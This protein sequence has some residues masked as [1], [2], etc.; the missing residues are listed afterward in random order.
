MRKRLTAVEV[1]QAAIRERLSA[2]ESRI[3][4]AV[5]DTKNETPLSA[6]L[7]KGLREVLHRDDDRF[8]GMGKRF[9]EGIERA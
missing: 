5:V 3:G 4:A 8:L 6:E 2:V 7:R 1:G 9:V